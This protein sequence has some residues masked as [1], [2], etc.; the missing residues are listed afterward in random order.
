MKPYKRHL[1]IFSLLIALLTASSAVH[2]VEFEVYQSSY[3][4]LNMALLSV[5]EDVYAEQKVLL[6]SIIEQDLNASRSFRSLDALS[7]LVSAEDTLE[8]ID[9]SDWRIIGT[10][11]LI[12]LNL[13][14]S[15]E[16]WVV[17]VQLHDPFRAKLIEQQQIQ[18]HDVQQLRKLGHRVADYIYHQQTGLP[19]YFLS[20]ITF[21]RNHG[22]KDDLMLMDH[23][24]EHLQTIGKNFT[25]L[26]SPDL[27][28]DR[29][30]IAL[31]TYVANRPRLEF[32]SL[33]DGKRTT[34][35]AFKGLNSTPEFSPDGRFVAAALSKTGNSE[36]HIYDIKKQKW[37][38]F[39]QHR[40]IDTTPTWSPDGKWIAFTSNRNGT[41]QIYRKSLQDGE[42]RRVSL[43]A[44]YNTS[45]V[46]APIGDRI[47]F[48]TKKAWEYA[49]ATVHIDGTGLRYLA[50][51]QRIESP[52]W[53]PNGQIVL[54]SAEEK[55]K[56]HIY[57]VPIWGGDAKR[58]TPLH[59]DAS[60]PTWSR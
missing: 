45:P 12:L 54:Y 22:Q 20:Q 35:A 6:N 52:A 5:S 34:F 51:G 58:I 10:D 56:K 7:F 8:A 15:A 42:V 25:L 17:D 44:N 27:S 31:N 32:F 30:M 28:P 37:K 57:Q 16:G 23:D 4:P 59:M 49:I 60:D 24:G 11:L 41:P 13:Q 29:T 47:A 38:R 36:I 46:W 39:T 3:K 18:H 9:Y 53:S 55:G 1:Y 19:G 48:V 26:L 40:A 21:V 33:E 2:A 50:T 14:R 43:A